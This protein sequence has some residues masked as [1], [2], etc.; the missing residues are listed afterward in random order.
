MKN[1]LTT[2]ILSLSVISLSAQS[3]QTGYVKTKGRLDGKGNVIHGKGIAGAAIELQGG[4]S[5]V[6]DATGKFIFTVP[7]RKFYLKNVQKNGYVVVDSDILSKYYV[8]SDN[9]LVITM[10]TPQQQLKDQLETQKRIAATLR[11]QREER[12][13][14]LD[15]LRAA[16]K[17][18]EE[19]YY[20]L[21]Q[22]LYDDNA[23]E[24]LVKEM[25]KRYA[26]MDFDLV[27]SF[28]LQISTLILNGELTKADSLLNTR[29]I[30][31]DI[32]TLD[33]I[34]KVIAEEDSVLRKRKATLDTAV[35]YE[36]WSRQD[37]VQT[38]SNKVE[39]FRRLHQN[40]S[41]AFYLMQK[42]DIDS[43]MVEWQLEAGQF[44]SDTMMDYRNA[45]SYYQRA[46]R[47]LREEYGDEH[48][49]TQEVMEK[50]V[51]L[52]RKTEK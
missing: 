46:L 42:A 21:M 12:E 48:P 52:Q 14:E 15:S 19:E 49:K 2:L 34:R 50:V 45:L 27:D 36:Q 26:E 7:N 9:P 39:T 30:L 5:T 44:L 6:S 1:F 47:K 43:N 28:Q 32:Y 23:N 13:K 22:Q 33:S 40:D 41:V 38:A 10:E 24:N 17:L 20:R 8:Q 16:H 18:T 4:H 51:A 25:S 11:Q 37:L 3:T 29:P 35:R 31:P